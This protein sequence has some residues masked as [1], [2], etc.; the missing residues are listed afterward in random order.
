MNA[1]RSIQATNIRS[2]FVRDLELPAKIGVHSHEKL[3][4][5]LIRINVDMATSAEGGP[6][7]D[8]IAN[9]VCYEDVVNGITDIVAGEHINLVETLAEKIAD[10]CLSDSRVLAVKIRVEKPHII[11][12]AASVGVEIERYQALPGTNGDDKGTK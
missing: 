3:D 8:D 9:V 5:Q 4:S 7:D 10:F 1:P 12:E 6:I 2:V 11:A